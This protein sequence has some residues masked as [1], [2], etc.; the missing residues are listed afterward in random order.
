[1]RAM[2]GM[3]EPPQP[4]CTRFVPSAQWRKKSVCHPF[5]VI[6]KAT[7]LKGGINFALQCPAIDNVMVVE[8]AR[9]CMRPF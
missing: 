9:H 7:S 1:M 2:R 8:I 6:R 4:L 3:E 5:Q